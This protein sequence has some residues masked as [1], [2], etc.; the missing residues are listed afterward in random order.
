MGGVRDKMPAKVEVL[1]AAN[2]YA[3]HGSVAVP[4]VV[5]PDGSPSF[6][7][8]QPDGLQGVHQR[9]VRG[10]RDINPNQDTPEKRLP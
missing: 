3:I 8:G 1:F 4:Y 10:I 6:D 7:Y 5:I 9:A 2:L